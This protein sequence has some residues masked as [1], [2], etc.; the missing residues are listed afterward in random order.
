MGLLASKR[1]VPRMNIPRASI[2]N[3]QAEGTA[4]QL[5]SILNIQSCLALALV[6]VT[7][8]TL[9]CSL[10]QPLVPK[11]TKEMTQIGNSHVF[12]AQTQVPQWPQN[13]SLNVL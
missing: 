6:L 9:L 10:S 8:L 13:A 12:S 3:R 5:R 7:T 4:R 1:Y 11:G 2:Y